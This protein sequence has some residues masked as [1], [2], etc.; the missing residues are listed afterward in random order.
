MRNCQRRVSSSIYVF[1][2]NLLVAC[3]TGL[4]DC[5]VHDLT[6]IPGYFRSFPS[7]ATKWIVGDVTGVRGPK[8]DVWEA[9]RR[10]RPDFKAPYFEDYPLIHDY[11]SGDDDS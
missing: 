11:A 9:T 7:Q 8:I 10:N 6:C 3:V 1:F 4:Q 5:R 2:S